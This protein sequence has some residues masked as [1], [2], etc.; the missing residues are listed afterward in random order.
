MLW[1]VMFFNPMKFNVQDR[2]WPEQN[3]ITAN[4]NE[5]IQWQINYQL[6]QNPVSNKKHGERT[7]EL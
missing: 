7:V 5:K 2:G 4:A 6:I 1:Y 3:T